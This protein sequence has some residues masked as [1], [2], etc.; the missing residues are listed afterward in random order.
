MGLHAAAVC[1]LLLCGL[2]SVRAVLAPSFR[3]VQTNDSFQLFLQEDLLARLCLGLSTALP[4]PSS[5][6]TA[7]ETRR[8][9]WEPAPPQYRETDGNFII[10]DTTTERL[11][12][13]QFEVT[14]LDVAT[15]ITLW[16]PDRADSRVTL[17]FSK[18]TD[19][20][21]V[22]GGAERPDLYNRLWLRLHAQGDETVFGGGEQYTFFNLRG[23]NYPIWTRE[24]GILRDPTNPLTW[25]ISL[26][27]GAGGSYDTTY[28]P[29]A[30]FLSS[31]GYYFDSSAGELGALNFSA[32]DHHEFY[33]QGVGALSVRLAVGA[34]PL[35]LVQWTNTGRQ[36]LP[37]WASDG[38]VLGVQGGT[39]VMLQRYEQAKTAGIRVAG[40]WIQDWAGRQDTTFGQRLFWNWRWNETLYPRLDEAIKSLDKEDVKVLAYINPHL[41]V[42][43]DIY[44][45][46]TGK[47]Y[48]LTDTAGDDYVLDFGGFRAATVDLLNEA[49]GTW[50]Q[51]LIQT[52]LLGLG[53]AGWMADFGEY[54]PADAVSSGAAA[55]SSPAALHNVYPSLWG[56]TN[57]RAVIAAGRENDTLF[58]VRAGNG[59]QAQHAAM[60][61]SGD[62]NTDWTTTDGVA[63]TL[64]SALS[65]AVT[66]CGLNHFDIGGYTT[67]QPFFWRSEE[68]LLRSAEY[69]LFTPV[70]RTHEG[71]RPASNVQWYS[72]ARTLAFFAHVSRAFAA[73]A[74]YTRAALAEY[75][76]DHTP[77]QRPTFL[78][79][80][81]ELVPYRAETAY[82]YLYG[83]DLLVAPVYRSGVTC[84][85]LRLPADRWVHLWSGRVW[86]GP[87]LVTVDAPLGQP[88]VFYRAASQWAPLFEEIGNMTLMMPQTERQPGLAATSGPDQEGMIA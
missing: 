36:L 51:Q 29:Q 62:Q 65:L 59:E 72:S 18:S 43:G 19:T 66:G 78:H 69:A 10:N 5:S 12:L 85:Q 4:G 54:V 81:D 1:S 16:A 26:D 3:I 64:V 44:L 42:E 71:S 28:W 87:A 47:G 79:Y 58:F 52:N 13:T 27:G 39:D 45:N 38:V 82:Q 41:N 17:R 37:D 23:R 70:M 22:G 76:R 75:G 20:V 2:A 11:A 9:S 31:R 21:D 84:R 32:A 55:L 73:L 33:T 49:A 6:T 61:W 86:S 24:Q 88:P 74:P 57:R 63:T 50:Y 46:N 56:R 60:S 14:Q 68:L 80:P 83:R 40:L 67:Q 30:S 15:A 77:L 35:E 34:G 53:M 8:H 25:I 7:R 48:F